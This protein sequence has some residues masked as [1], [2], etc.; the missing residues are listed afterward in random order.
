MIDNVLQFKK[1]LKHHSIRF[2][3]VC[4]CISALVPAT[5]ISPIRASH[6]FY[7]YGEKSP[8]SVVKVPAAILN[9]GGDI[10]VM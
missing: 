5:L 10:H 3:Y 7:F 8:A 1:L 9:P 6:F 4:K 2:R